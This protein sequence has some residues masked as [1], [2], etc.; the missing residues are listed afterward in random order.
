MS[1]SLGGEPTLEQAQKSYSAD[2]GVSMR[3]CSHACLLYVCMHVCCH[4]CMSAVRKDV[5]SVL[6][7]CFTLSLSLQASE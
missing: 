5:H 4:A 7:S 6:F 2:Q 1:R 3:V